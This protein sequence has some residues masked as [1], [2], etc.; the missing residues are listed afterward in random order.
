MFLTLFSEVVRDHTQINSDIFFFIKRW[1]ISLFHS[2]TIPVK[3]MLRAWSLSQPKLEG[4]GILQ[5]KKIKY[6]KKEIKS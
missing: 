1:G 4:L 2:I 3:L 5:S 6:F